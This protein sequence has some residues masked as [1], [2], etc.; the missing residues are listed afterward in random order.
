MRLALS[1]ILFAAPHVG[2]GA[3]LGSPPPPIPVQT[4]AG[5][6]LDTARALHASGAPDGDSETQGP[7][8]APSSTQ[9]ELLYFE[10]GKAELSNAG[11]EKLAA[12]VDAWGASGVW[13]V[14]TSKEDGPS[15]ALAQARFDT[16][17]LILRRLSVLR[18]EHRPTLK[19]IPGKFDAIRIGKTA[20]P[21]LGPGSS[22]GA[23]ASDPAASLNGRSRS[24]VGM[25]LQ[26]GLISATNNGSSTTTGYLP[27]G[28]LGLHVDWGLTP[29]WTLRPR[30]EAWYFSKERQEAATFIGSQ[31]IESRKVAGLIGADLLYAHNAT[32]RW[33][34]GAGLYLAHWKMDSKNSIQASDGS[35]IASAGSTVWDR[36]AYSFISTLRLSPALEGELRWVTSQYGYE[37]QPVHVM[38][39]SLF[40]KF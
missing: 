28:A 15:A 19:A 20:A 33:K 17:E 1:L 16:V 31:V 12:W 22:A 11:K 40:W 14:L 5:P 34:L 10:K 23:E 26:L 4:A 8:L 7:D 36:P 6:S 24:W 39:L 27:N 30:A 13:F 35:T 2:R 3:T 21:P 25:G 32:T 9:S 38:A 18:V 29:Q 37:N